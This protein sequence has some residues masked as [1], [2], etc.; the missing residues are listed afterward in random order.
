MKSDG[1]LP[2]P[3]KPLEFPEDQSLKMTDLSSVQIK[4]PPGVDTVRQWGQQVLPEGKKQGMTFA[5]VYQE[6]AR[7]RALMM[8]H[9]HLTSAWALSYQNY[10]RARSKVESGLMANTSSGNQKPVTRAPKVSEGSDWELM[11]D[12]ENQGKKT[13]SKRAASSATPTMMTEKD[14]EKEQEIMTKIAILQREL[15][16]VKGKEE[17]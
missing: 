16:M 7:Y 9:S 3:D 4:R 15:A 8:N 10:V 13:T 17:A 1:H 6:D 12:E 14:P 2:L 11:I 5:Q